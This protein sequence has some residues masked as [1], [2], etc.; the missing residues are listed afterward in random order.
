M[1]FPENKALT[2]KWHTTLLSDIDELKM[3]AASWA[4]HDFASDLA[5]PKQAL[6]ALFDQLRK[7]VIDWRYDN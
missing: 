5:T 6:A 1:E 3:I 7:N 2:D 4:Y